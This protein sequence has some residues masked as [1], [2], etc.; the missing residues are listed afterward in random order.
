MESRDHLDRTT[1]LVL[2]GAIGSAL[3]GIELEFHSG[4]ELH[5]CQSASSLVQQCSRLGVLDSDLR[6]IAFCF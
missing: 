6:F 2:L 5:Y 3:G 4:V 1:T